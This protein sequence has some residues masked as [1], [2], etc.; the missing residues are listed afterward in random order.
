[1]A[2][3]AIPFPIPSTCHSSLGPCSGHDLRSPVSDETPS[4]FGPRHWGQPS[5][6][7]A[8]EVLE[9]LSTAAAGESRFDRT[10]DQAASNGRKVRMAGNSHEGKSVAGRSRAESAL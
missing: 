9:F 1:M 2:T 7:E 8:S 5:E 4:R 6:A 10:N 3:L